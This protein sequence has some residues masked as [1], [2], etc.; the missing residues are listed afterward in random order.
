[1]F[2]L[3]PLPMQ[4]TQRARTNLLRLQRNPLALPQPP[5]ASSEPL[6]AGK[7]L[8]ALLEL[9]ICGGVVCV[10]GPEE[11]AAVIGER[12]E[13]AFGTVDV[14]LEVAVARVDFGF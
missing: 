11:R 12:C 7:Q 2:N 5:R 13:F 14:S 9:V 8:L 6:S 1:M 3:L 4:I 10:A